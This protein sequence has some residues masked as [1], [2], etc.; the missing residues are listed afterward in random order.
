MKRKK[1]KPEIHRE[2]VIDIKMLNRNPRFNNEIIK[3]KS[4]SSITKRTIHTNTETARYS[5]R[6]ILNPDLLKSAFKSGKNF[7]YGYTC[8]PKRRMANFT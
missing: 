6:V 1:K 2:I 8:L 7:L 4:G 5:S 3:E